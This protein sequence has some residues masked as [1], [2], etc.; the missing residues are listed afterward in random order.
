HRADAA[1]LAQLQKERDQAKAAAD[2]AAE[3]L[4]KN[5]PGQGSGLYRQAKRL[6]LDG[7]VDEAIQLLEDEKLRQ[8]VAQAKQALED[9]VQGWL[10]KAQMLTL[11]FRFEEAERAYLH[12]IEAKPE[13]FEANFA[14]GLLGRFPG[15]SGGCG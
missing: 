11:K 4:A 9:A 7:K 8:A 12:A 5:Q 14:Y 1:A 3:E 10:L 6:F 13:G 2:K 15:E